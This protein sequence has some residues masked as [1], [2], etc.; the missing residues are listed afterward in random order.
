VHLTYDDGSKERLTR[1]AVDEEIGGEI[2]V[3]KV[4]VRIW[5]NSPLRS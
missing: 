5:F 3:W 1:Q 2:K 4:D